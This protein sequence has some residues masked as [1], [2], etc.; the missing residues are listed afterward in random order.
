MADAYI[1]KHQIWSKLGILEFPKDS[2]F[3][4]DYKYFFAI[5]T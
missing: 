5:L 4:D 2:L 1:R 3:F